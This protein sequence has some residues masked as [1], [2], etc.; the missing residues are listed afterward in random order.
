M[1]FIDTRWSLTRNLQGSTAVCFH[2]WSC[3][4]PSP[5]FPTSEFPLWSCVS[6]PFTPVNVQRLR[7]DESDA[8]W[9]ISKGRCCWGWDIRH[10]L[11]ERDRKNTGKKKTGVYQT[12]QQYLVC[13]VTS[14]GLVHNKELSSRDR[15]AVG[16]QRE[17]GELVCAGWGSGGWG[18]AG[19]GSC[20]TCSCCQIVPGRSP[21]LWQREVSFCLRVSQFISAQSGCRLKAF[22]PKPKSP[23]R[24][25]EDAQQIYTYMYCMYVYMYAYINT[26][27]SISCLIHR[28]IWR[29][30]TSYSQGGSLLLLLKLDWKTQ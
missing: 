16:R 18:A 30:V 8:P 20:P 22:P 10:H 1:V 9:E 21:I 17:G 6:S 13:P 14:Q 3:R 27:L 11:E 25:E 28:N 5:F 23:L 29:L 12:Q 2:L 19:S 26:L 15:R 4:V 24:K 7:S